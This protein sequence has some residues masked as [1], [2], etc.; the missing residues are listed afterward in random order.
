MVSMIYLFMRETRRY[1]L[2]EIPRV[3]EA[4]SKNIMSYRLYVEF[5]YLFKRYILRKDVELEHFEDS[6]YNT[7]MISL[8]NIDTTTS[9]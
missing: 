8:D 1:P 5:P 9:V 2:E 6:R 3:F 7:G 4:S